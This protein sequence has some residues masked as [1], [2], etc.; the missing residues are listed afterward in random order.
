MIWPGT[1][2][3]YKRKKTIKFLGISAGVGIVAVLLTMSIVNPFIGEQ[4]RNACINNMQWN[5][6]S[7]PV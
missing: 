2:D 1:N 7:A 4:P 3:P 6:V 5:V